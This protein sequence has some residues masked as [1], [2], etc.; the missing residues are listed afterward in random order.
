MNAREKKTIF[1]TPDKNVCAQISCIYSLLH[2]P[3]ADVRS[4][5]IYIYVNYSITEHDLACKEW[6]FADAA[7]LKLLRYK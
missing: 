4:S 7:T 2:V 1:S 3:V 6:N 5:Y